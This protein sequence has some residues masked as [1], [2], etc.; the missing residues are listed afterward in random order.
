MKFRI[1][2]ELSF[3]MRN[4]IL[5]SK[6]YIMFS[7]ST[8]FFQCRCFC[9]NG[10]W[11]NGL[12][13]SWLPHKHLSPHTRHAFNEL[14]SFIV[15]SAFLEIV[16]QEP[17]KTVPHTGGL[18]C[19]C[20]EQWRYS[21]LSSVQITDFQYQILCSNTRFL[22]SVLVTQAPWICVCAIRPE[23]I[24]FNH[25]D[26]EKDRAVNLVTSWIHHTRSQLDL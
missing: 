20:Q 6:L 25:S 15:C 4:L 17:L 2:N 7:L 26:K 23:A 10:K 18:R 3:F 21:E 24:C 14:V 22:I 9:E 8:Y 12:C 5:S 16:E 1:N 19:L 11:V 13:H